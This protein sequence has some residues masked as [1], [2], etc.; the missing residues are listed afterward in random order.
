MAISFELQATVRNDAGKGASRRLR[1]EGKVPAILYGAGD[2]PLM[3][4]LEHNPVMHSLENEA[5]YSHILNVNVGGKTV[6]A[7]LKDL[8]R[9]PYKPVL[10][11]L[12]LQRVSEKEKLRM[13]VPLHFL[14]EENAASVKQLG[15][16]VSR[17]VSEVEVSCLPKDLP[18]Y[19]EVDVSALGLGETLHLSNLKLPAGVELIAL[20]HGSEH[21]LPVVSVHL[22]R[23]A[24]E[25]DGADAAKPEG[26]AG[27]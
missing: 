19:I 5:F 21:D 13:S 2:A 24:S 4:S 12:D 22:P 17:L 23:G 11:H 8:Q 25:S 18:E 7:V 27:G 9:H 10:L 20:T 14:G 15:G 6:R 3:L 1:R 16:V 26:A